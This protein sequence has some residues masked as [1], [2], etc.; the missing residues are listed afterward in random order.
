MEKEFFKQNF[1]CHGIQ[2]AINV[3]LFVSCVN[4]VRSTWDSWSWKALRKILQLI[5]YLIRL[6]LS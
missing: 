2:R 1:L 6:E 5:I 4:R 3:G